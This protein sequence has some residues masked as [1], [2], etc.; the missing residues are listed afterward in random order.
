M[1]QKQGSSRKLHVYLESSRKVGKGYWSCSS[2]AEGLI[3]AL[4][5][6][7]WFAPPRN[8]WPKPLR[9]S[10]FLPF[11]Q[12]AKAELL[13][14]LQSLASPSQ[15]VPTNMYASQHN[16]MGDSHKCTSSPCQTMKSFR[17]TSEISDVALKLNIQTAI[18]KNLKNSVNSQ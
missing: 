5:E 17:P 6:L 8:R 9:G 12:L 11:M 15:K 3:V 4:L 14:S 2:E 16:G 7:R 13:D 1:L 18:L 10:K